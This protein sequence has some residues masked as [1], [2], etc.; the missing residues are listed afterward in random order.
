M[1][2][3]E[4]AEAIEAIDKA[5]PAADPVRALPGYIRLRKYVLVHDVISVENRD[6]GL[7]TAPFDFSKATLAARADA[8]YHDADQALRARPARALPQGLLRAAR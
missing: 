1:K 4:F 6:P 5:L 8:G 3:N 7:V 2:V